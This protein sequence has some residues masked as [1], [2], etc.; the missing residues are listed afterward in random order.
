MSAKP[1]GYHYLIKENWHQFIIS[2]NV[3]SMWEFPQLFPALC[4]LP[5]FFFFSPNMV[6]S[7]FLWLY[8]YFLALFLCHN[9][10]SSEEPGAIGIEHFTF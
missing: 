7:K 1:Q 8:L 4:F 3:L 2:S 10:N 5:F 6:H 9:I